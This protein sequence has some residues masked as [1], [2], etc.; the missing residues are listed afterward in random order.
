M[1]YS[2]NPN[3]GTRALAMAAAICALPHA[4]AFDANTGNGDLSIRWDNTLKYSSAFRVQ[5]QRD[6]LLTGDVF[7][8]NT[9]DGDRNFNRGLISN[10][11]DWLS[12]LDVVYAKQYGLRISAA[13]WYDSVYNSRNDNNSPGTANRFSGPYNSFNPTTRRLHGRD[14]EL[15]DAFVFGRFD[16]GATRLNLRAGKHSV[17][18]GESLFFGSNAIAGAMA[19]VDVI[20]LASVPSTQFKEAILP[21]PQLSAQW[22]LNSDVSLGAFYQFRWKASRL[23]AAGSYFSGLDFQPDGGEG[24]YLPGFPHPLLRAANQNAKHSGQGGLQLRF[25][26]LD[27]D[28]GLY[29]VRFHNKTHQLVTDLVPPGLPSDYHLAYQQGITAFGASASHTFGDIQLAVEASLRRNQDLSSTAANDLSALFHAPA[30]DNSGNPAYAVGRT[31]HVNVS[32]LW[33]LP[34]SPLAR[35]ASLTA[36]VMWNRVLSVQKNPQAL[37]PNSTRDAWAFRTVLEPTYR[38]ILPGLDISV[39]I[40]VGWSPKGSRS[41][42]LGPGL[43]ADNGGDISIGIKGSYLDVWRPSL[44]Y[45]HF[46]GPASN[47]MS[48]FPPAFTYRQFMKDRDF[49]AVSISRTF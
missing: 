11:I 31:A 44:S 48:G 28:F 29:A 43:P 26:A 13:G 35:E 10:R 7:S 20:K 36:E 8:A 33:T 1:R 22:Q 14:A 40:G 3:H 27:T 18:W 17:L 15:L 4:R 39:P 49:I 21:V 2:N 16:L 12:E 42:A 45:T 25:S 47:M 34:S 6:T 23:P 32:S 19:P 24:M 37:D 46:Y 5:R 41:Q 30:N 38:Q 9:D